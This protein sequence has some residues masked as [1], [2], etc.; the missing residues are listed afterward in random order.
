MGRL[1]TTR[2]VSKEKFQKRPR[3]KFKCELHLRVTTNDSCAGFVRV[4]AVSFFAVPHLS[5]RKIPRTSTKLIPLT[6]QVQVIC[7][8]SLLA[9]AYCNLSYFTLSRLPSTSLNNLLHTAKGKLHKQMMFFCLKQSIHFLLNFP[10]PR[11][12]QH[13]SEEYE[14]THNS[15][16]SKQSTS[17]LVN[18]Y[19]RVRE[20]TSN[21]WFERLSFKRI[22]TVLITWSNYISK[23]WYPNPT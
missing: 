12:W 7:L 5:E 17:L 8:S 23:R 16:M 9:P 20:W 1:W 22:L 14:P 3:Y 2:N 11:G 18:I 13:S 4:R 10:E 6:K 21:Y 15:T 19:L